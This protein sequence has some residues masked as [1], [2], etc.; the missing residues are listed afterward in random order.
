MACAVSSN[1]PTITALAQSHHKTVDAMQHQHL[2]DH[3]VHNLVRHL[4][5]V[6]IKA[7]IDAASHITFNLAAPAVYRRG[8]LLRN[9]SD[10]IAAEE[11]QQRFAHVGVLG[12]V[13]CF[14]HAVGAPA[15]Q[16]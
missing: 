14:H 15:L 11:R 10:M 5:H 8:Q 16:Q 12:L 3:L 4:S 2:L 6:C 13:Q 7:A 9:R 1:E